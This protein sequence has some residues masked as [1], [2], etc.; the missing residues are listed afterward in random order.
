MRR[1]PVWIALL[2]ALITIVLWWSVA[3][4]YRS[5]QE[6][7]LS[8]WIE[9]QQ[10]LIKDKGRSIAAWFDLRLGETGGDPQ[11]VEREVIEK[12]IA[13]TR[14]Y[15]NGEPWIFTKTRSV[16]INQVDIPEEVR[17][18]GI[19]RL[20]DYQKERGATHYEDFVQGV[21]NATE[22]SS[23]YVWQPQLGREFVAWS[24]FQVINE[25]WT[26][27]ISTSEAKILAASGIQD[28]LLRE[29]FGV[30]AITVLLWGIYLLFLRQQQITSGQLS[31]MQISVTDQ[32]SLAQKV[33]NQ[34]AELTVI[35]QALEKASA[36]KDEF[37]ANMSHELRT[38]LNTITG[39]AYALQCQ[40]YGPVNEKQ[41]YSLNTILNTSQNLS[42]LIDNILDYSNIQSRKIHIE[43]KPVI[44]E[45]FLDSCLSVVTQPANEK[46]IQLEVDR[47]LQVETLEADE[48]R[49]RQVLVNLLTNAV[50][51]TLPGGKA[52]LRV[53]CDPENQ[54]IK[55]TVWDTGIGIDQKEMQRLFKPFVQLAAGYD[56]PHSG[57]GLG[58][59]L[60]A[61][62]MDL[63]GG[64]VAAESEAGKGS[65]F[66][67]TLPWR[68]A[69]YEE[70][71]GGSDA[72]RILAR[73]PRLE[74][75]VPVLVVDDDPWGSQVIREFLSAAGY[76][77]ALAPSG[78]E[79]LRVLKEFKPR[80]VLIDLQ[81]PGM[82]GMQT[83][84][85]FHSAPENSALPILAL[86]SI[87]LP[88]DRERCLQAGASEYLQKPIRLDR[89]VQVMNRLVKNN[90]DSEKSNG[91]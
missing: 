13:P 25:T 4:Y 80:L 76:T 36:A 15:E 37:T 14:Q 45:D 87:V 90:P 46:Q 35:N 33:S 83:I 82:D 39:L 8:N 64:S 72:T 75:P 18:N 77:V 65:Q 56:R 43:I 27:G 85:V 41:S 63:H 38:P 34:S 67:I 51:F 54:E 21:Q 29:L 88:G 86:T 55:L 5:R 31:A 22:G 19:E 44:L 68:G 11:V 42:A 59:L 30:G 32:I 3:L 89:L 6:A 74:M 26:L 53:R 66:T 84:R 62:I 50:K 79:G 58:L 78:E 12:Y 91:R 61:R 47:D 40:V 57:T 49:L 28:N 2:F 73:I 9:I 70:N 71:S 52:G 60:V 10:I 17:A 69:G 81:M 48:V 23:W 16:Y 20:F 7:I 1:V 24:S